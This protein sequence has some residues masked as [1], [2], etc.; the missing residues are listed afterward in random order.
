MSE[1]MNQSFPFRFPVKNLGGKSPQSSDVLWFREHMRVVVVADDFIQFDGVKTFF[2]S[3]LRERI[4][5]MPIVFYDW[6]A[7]SMIRVMASTF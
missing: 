5:L 6:K 3:N 1:F 2:F 7:E 4:G